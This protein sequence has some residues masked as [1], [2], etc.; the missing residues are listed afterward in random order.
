MSADQVR[1]VWRDVAAAIV[2]ALAVSAALWAMVTA[3]AGRYPV[4]EQFA[5]ALTIKVPLAS[6][7]PLS[8]K[9]RNP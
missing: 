4:E 5:P 1:P 3:G 2:L 8:I 9:E 6:P 7:P